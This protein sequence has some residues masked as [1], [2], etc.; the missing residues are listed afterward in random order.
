MFNFDWTG[1]IGLIATGQSLVLLFYIVGK[2]RAR[3]VLIIPFLLVLVLS[4]ALI[5]DILLHTKLA[6]YFPHIVG[7]GPLHSYIIGPIVL[8]LTFKLIKPARKLSHWHALHFIPFAIQLWNRS[9][10]LL[11]NAA[12]KQAF[13]EN[14]LASPPVFTR[15]EFNL[16]N[17]IQTV[18]FHGH[19]FVYFSYAIYLLIRFK[20]E[21]KYA[22]KSRENFSRLLRQ[23]LIVYCLFWGVLRCLLFVPDVAELVF[24]LNNMFNSVGI[25]MMVIVMANFCFNYSIDEVFSTKDTRK[26]LKGGLDDQ[27]VLNILRELNDY[28][29]NK[30]YFSNPDLKA[31]DV[32][33]LSGYN[34]HQISQAINLSEYSSFNSMLNHFRIEEFKRLLA[35]NSEQKVELLQLAFQAGFNSKATFNRS[36]KQQTGLTPRQYRI[37]LES[38]Q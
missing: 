9:S 20:D 38:E 35:K 30:N 34:Q 12:N 3:R 1:I 31:K 36:F 15:L 27:L 25:S 18:T 16:N 23:F 22:V 17:I 11:Q 32:A 7:L 26:Y 10:H 14:Y 8:L 13:I 2:L 24:T 33:E 19:R 4:L 28:L 6:I 29:S 21:F 5:H 37:E